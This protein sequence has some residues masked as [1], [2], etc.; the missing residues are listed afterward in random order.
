MNDFDTLLQF[1]VEWR[2]AWDWLRILLLGNKVK[3]RFMKITGLEICVG[4]L[5]FSVG[6]VEVLSFFVQSSNF[7]S[8]GNPPR[9]SHDF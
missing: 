7:T 6:V 4:S 3:G 5:F 2:D 8:Y 1:L 9:N